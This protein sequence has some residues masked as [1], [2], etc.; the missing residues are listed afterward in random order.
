MEK[1]LCSEFDC[2]ILTNNKNR[3]QL[4]SSY[5][6]RSTIKRMC[7][8]F[9]KKIFKTERLICIATDGHTKIRTD[10]QADMAKSTP[11]LALIQNIYIPYGINDVF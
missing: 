2:H 10:G 7:A 4:V 1:I 6:Q 3:I 9:H 11:L 8:K 5:L